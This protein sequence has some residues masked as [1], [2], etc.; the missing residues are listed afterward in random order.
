VRWSTIKTQPHF[1]PPGRMHTVCFLPGMIFN[2]MV[3]RTKGARRLRFL[4]LRSAN[5]NF[6]SHENILLKL[7]LLAFEAIGF[8]PVSWYS[9]S[10][11]FLYKYPF[12]YQSSENFEPPKSKP[13]C[14]FDN[15]Q[16]HFQIRLKENN[17]FR[18]IL[19]DDV[20]NCLPII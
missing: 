1:R 12:V 20:S 9:R 17:K 5:I 15:K 4:F 8:P 19:I 11:C 6:F 13:E 16:T 18:T 14:S 10:R 3:R 7:P 2:Q